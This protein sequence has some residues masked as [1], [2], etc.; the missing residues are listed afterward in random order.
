[1]IRLCREHI[2]LM[3]LFDHHNRVIWLIPAEDVLL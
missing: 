3:V 1:M 2:Y